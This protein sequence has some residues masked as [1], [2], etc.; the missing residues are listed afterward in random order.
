MKKL[1]LTLFLINLIFIFKTEIKSLYYSNS[2]DT[3][4]YKI[5]ILGDSNLADETNIGSILN[6]NQKIAVYNESKKGRTIDDFMDLL[7]N[8][9]E[10][11]LA[12]IN[13]THIIVYLGID[14]TELAIKTGIDK[15]YKQI[16]EI[17]KNIS[18]IAI[19]LQITNLN[20][21]S[22]NILIFNKQ[23]SDS[24]SLIAYHF[25]TNDEIEDLEYIFDGIHL[26]TKSQFIITKLIAKRVF[27]ISLKSIDMKSE[28]CYDKDFCDL[29][30]AIPLNKL[31]GLD[32]VSNLNFPEITNLND[33]LYKE[34]KSKDN[35]QLYKVYN[36]RLRKFEDKYCEKN[37]ASKNILSIV[38]KNDEIVKYTLHYLYLNKKWFEVYF[39]PNCDYP[40]EYVIFKDGYHLEKKLLFPVFT[41]PL[42]NLKEDYKLPKTYFY[43]I[44]EGMNI[45]TDSAENYVYDKVCEWENYIS[46][47]N[48]DEQFKWF[49]W[50]SVF[51]HCVYYKTNPFKVM[52]SD[53]MKKYSQTIY[54]TDVASDSLGV[55][56]SYS[57]SLKVGISP[58]PDIL[59]M[60][61]MLYS[62]FEIENQFPNLFP[63]YIM[64]LVKLSLGN[65]ETKQ[66]YGI[67]T[68]VGII[69]TCG[70]INP[71][72]VG[73]LQLNY[74]TAEYYSKI[75][76][77]FF[78]QFY[79]LDEVNRKVIFHSWLT[80]QMMYTY[81]I[82]RSKVKDGFS[83][84]VDF[85]Q[86][87]LKASSWHRS[88]LSEK[89]KYVQSLKAGLILYDD[90]F[91]QYFP[92]NDEIN[93]I[94][95]EVIRIN[96]RKENSNSFLNIAEF[97]EVEK[98]V[99]DN[100]NIL[101]KNYP[102][103]LANHSKSNIFDLTSYDENFMT[104]FTISTEYCKTI[105]DNEKTRFYVDNDGHIMYCFKKNETLYQL[106][107]NRIRKWINYHNSVVNDFDKSK[108]FILCAESKEDIIVLNEKF[109]YDDLP[110]EIKEVYSKKDYEKMRDSIDYEY[111]LFEEFQKMGF[112][113]KVRIGNYKNLKLEVAGLKN[114]FFY[115]NLT[116][117]EYKKALIKLNENY[118]FVNEGD[119]FYIP[120]TDFI[121][122]KEN[123]G[124]FVLNLYLNA[125]ISK[126]NLANESNF[127]KNI[128]NEVGKDL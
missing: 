66:V 111:F 45:P 51:S 124:Y 22:D 104:N 89:H 95:N 109:D 119:N 81:T 64:N 82:A 80:E 128:I 76:P 125:L 21:L 39:P 63:S 29:F 4:D 6:Y 60:Y 46:T 38:D 61:S 11:K 42:I 3:V 44:I 118:K 88:K 8:D 23:I 90:F 14:N 100:K 126:S 94:M 30:C 57:N 27:E 121:Y 43:K 17:N 56:N 87:A 33:S 101:S 20:K 25:E 54:Y 1:L 24:Q 107:Q 85:S 92:N 103:E 79:K 49:Y 31:Q 96:L 99:V 62:S 116:S 70:S 15:L 120:P 110:F 36:I 37:M 28:K 84:T 52:V 71:E 41:S 74:T 108:N 127:M 97:L 69:S 114:Q 102:K 12:I 112:D 10:L 75:N 55:D 115:G 58:L 93:N 16:L 122:L 83:E 19:D 73:A 78:A 77:A 9:E 72:D 65:N 117:L 35:K 113:I 59:V 13:S 123:N 105:T 34:P 47:L 53:E 86:I 7:K 5:V 40:K 32:F 106:G 98:I 68:D 50:K 2:K 67:Q 26:T 91:S 18:I 48:M